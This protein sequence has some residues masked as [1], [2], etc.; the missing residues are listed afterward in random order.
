MTVCSRYSKDEEEAKEIMNDAFV[1]VFTK[2]EKYNNTL[3]FKAWINKILVNTAID[4]F[5]KNQTV[6]QTVDLIHAQFVETSEGIVDELSAKELLK[7]VQK[8]SPAY[9]MVFSLYVIEGF[10]HAEIAQQLEISPGTSKSN[11]A[12]ARMKLRTLI[13]SLG[14]KKSKY[15]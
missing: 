4:Y 9:R 6:P 8:L 12:K 3:S 11:L 2:L 5:R 13:H 1:K 10:K 14:D 15:G 7:L